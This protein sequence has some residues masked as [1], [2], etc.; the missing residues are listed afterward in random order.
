MDEDEAAPSGRLL[1]LT[2]HDLAQ[3]PPAVAH[4]VLAKY[5]GLVRGFVRRFPRALLGA[6]FDGDD[7]YN[8][9]RVM[10]LQF[11]ILYD[12]SRGRSEGG[13]SFQGWA[14]F[15]FRQA[16]AKIA[17]DLSSCRE[18][19]TLLVMTGE[20][21]FDDST[22]GSSGRGVNPTTQ[23]WITEQL[24]LDRSED[25]DDAIDET[26]EIALFERALE[27][28]PPRQ[29]FILDGL[30]QG[31]STAQVAADLGISR[32]RVDQIRGPAMVAL[33]RI[34]RELR[35]EEDEIRPFDVEPEVDDDADLCS[36][37][38]RSPSTLVA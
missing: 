27:E 23:A 3:I 26:F 15:L 32:Q 6:R 28:L 34:L 29:R 5:D 20:R 30:R 2:K 18:F 31:R 8:I 33:C 25:V 37:G 10:L 35:G 19:P 11:W 14:T 4:E 9:G 16:L 36:P 1:H 13:G 22:Q 24:T 12:P 21:V 17:K 7:L 38:Y